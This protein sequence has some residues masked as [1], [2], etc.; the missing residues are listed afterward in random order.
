MVI[1]IE[2]WSPSAHGRGDGR[3]DS[4]YDIAAFL[5]NLTDR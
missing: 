2:L 1:G 5:E 4:N 3:T